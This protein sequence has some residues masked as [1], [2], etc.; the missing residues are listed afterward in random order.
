MTPI[1]PSA[2]WVLFVIFTFK[3]KLKLRKFIF[4]GTSFRLFQ[5]AKY[6]NFGGV[7]CEIRN[8]PLLI[9][10]TY[11]LR[12]VKKQVLLFLSSWEPNLSDLMFYFYLFQN[13][14]LYRIEARVW[15][16]KPFFSE[17]N[18]HWLRHFLSTWAY[19]SELK[20][21]LNIKLSHKFLTFIS[22]NIWGWKCKSIRFSHLEQGTWQF[23]SQM[24]FPNI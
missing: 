5:S 12:K 24:V 6:L 1:F 15:N 19:L 13:A 20:F 8:F 18:L 3:I 11:T 23:G 17:C 10:E 2:F 14:I 4:V 7:S 16:F 22:F 9:Q 21:A